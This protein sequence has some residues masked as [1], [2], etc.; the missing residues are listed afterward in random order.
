MITSYILKKFC[1]FKFFFQKDKLRHIKLVVT[2][3]DGVLTDGFI[4][5]SD[6]GIQIRKFNVKD[7]LGIKLLQHFG[8]EVAF[9]SGGKGNCIIERAN[10]LN[11][12][13]CFLETKNKKEVLKKLQK[14]LNLTPNQTAYLGDDL[15]DI[16]VKNLVSIMI[17]PSDSVEAFKKKCDLILENPGGKGAFREFVDQLLLSKNNSRFLTNNG[18]FESN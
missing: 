13:H 9:I 11:V 8:I 16:S 15:N 10:H 18:W 7:G 12:K 14:E 3:I 2:D 6:N 4:Y 17:A 5:L 1:N